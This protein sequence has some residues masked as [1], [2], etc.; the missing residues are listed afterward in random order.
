[1]KKARNILLSLI[2]VICLTA[3]DNNVNNNEN[4]NP[5]NETNVNGEEIAEYFLTDFEVERVK[6]S[7]YEIPA[8]T[9]KIE[10]EVDKTINSNTLRNL[11][12]YDFVTYKTDNYLVNE[13]ANEVRYS[14]I[15]VID[16]LEYLEVESYSELQLIDNEAG[17][18]LLPASKI[19]ANSYLVFYKNG[20]QIGEGKVDFVIPGMVDIFWGKGLKSITII[21]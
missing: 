19:D 20:T 6:E 11:K 3:C 16:V 8:F 7:K 2:A 21:K 9:L 13:K 5:N 15:K 17:E 1:M 12:V 14:G 4:N 10:G 18:I